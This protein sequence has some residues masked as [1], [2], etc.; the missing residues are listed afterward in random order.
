MIACDY[1]TQCT[2]R[3]GPAGEIHK[4]E[5]FSG[6]EILPSGPSQV[7]ERAQF[8]YFGKAL[9]ELIKTIKNQGEKQITETEEH[10]K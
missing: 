2:A 3:I 8:T 1:R 9:Q 10:G 7:L 4:Y 6:E 5:Y